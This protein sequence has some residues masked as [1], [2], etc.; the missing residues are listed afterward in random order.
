MEG[1][2]GAA[3]SIT[4]GINYRSTLNE[5]DYFH[6]ASGQLPQDVMHVL[7]EGV[8]IMEMKLLLRKFVYEDKYFN[9]DTFNLRISHFIYGRVEAR[10]KPP[11]TFEESHVNGKSKLPLSGAQLCIHS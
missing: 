3:D 10:N 1:V 5:I 2:T 6:V 4:Y 7:F 8:L 9:L 11:K